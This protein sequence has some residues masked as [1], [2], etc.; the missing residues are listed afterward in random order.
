MLDSHYSP[1]IK[2]EAEA[3]IRH[4]EYIQEIIKAA[5]DFGQMWSKYELFFD[6]NPAS[7]M[8]NKEGK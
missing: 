8:L 6:N 4:H 7:K 1:V 2:H 3:L 5:Y